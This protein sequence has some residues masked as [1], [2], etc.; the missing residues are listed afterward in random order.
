MK[1]QM[2]KC[3]IRFKCESTEFNSYRK[4]W[5]SSEKV[6]CHNL[7]RDVKNTIQE[8]TYKIQNSNSKVNIKFKLVNKIYNTNR[9]S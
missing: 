2:R 1:I 7:N 5:Y 8:R 4:V 9:N 3:S 6:E